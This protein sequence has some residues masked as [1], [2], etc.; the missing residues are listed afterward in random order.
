MGGGNTCLFMIVKVSKNK[1]SETVSGE[2]NLITENER[3]KWINCDIFSQ[4]RTWTTDLGGKFSI[5]GF[6]CRWEKLG[7]SDGPNKVKRGF[8]LCRMFLVL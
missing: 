1:D 5:S 3:T 8:L 2:D 7:N 4:V 6:K